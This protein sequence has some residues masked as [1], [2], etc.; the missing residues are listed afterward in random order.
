MLHLLKVSEKVLS[1]NNRYVFGGRGGG[2]YSLKASRKYLQIHRLSEWFSQMMY[3]HT[4][5]DGPTNIPC[6]HT[7]H[8]EDLQK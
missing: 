2:E 3:G 7:V 5:I 8:F 6:I 4:F 1:L